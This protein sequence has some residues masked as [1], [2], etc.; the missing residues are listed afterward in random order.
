VVKG[1]KILPLRRLSRLYF[2]ASREMSRAAALVI[3]GS[4]RA[5]CSRVAR[6]AAV[7]PAMGVWDAEAEIFP[8]AGNLVTRRC[9]SGRAHEKGAQ[10]GDDAVHRPKIWGSFASTIQNYEL[11]LYEK[12][13]SDLGTRAAGPISFTTVVSKWM[14]KMPR[15]RIAYHPGA[16]LWHCKTWVLNGIML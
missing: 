8:E 2:G 12:G 9:H 4:L 1:V 7:C 11:V 5:T 10:T 13:F 15:S 16:L 3:S 6:S 14:N